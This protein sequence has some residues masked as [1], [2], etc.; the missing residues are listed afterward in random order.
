MD[1]GAGFHQLVFALLAVVAA[2]DGEAVVGADAFPVFA[3]G[4]VVAVAL[5]V[6]KA[7]VFHRQV[8]VVLD[9]FGAIV[10]RK[11][12]QVFL[13]VDIDLFFTSFV[14]K[15]QLVAALTLVG[16]GFQGGSCFVFWQRVRRCIG[17]VVGSSGN[18]RL[19]RVAVQEGNDHFVANSWQGHKAV[20]AT[21]PA[22]SHAQPGAGVF[23]ISGVTIPRKSY[24]HPTILIAVDFFPFRAGHDGHLGAVHHGFVV[25]HWPPRFV[26][27]DGG[28]VVVVA[29]GFAATFFFQGLEL[30]A[31]VGDGREQP[32]P[33]QGLA[34]VVL[35]FHFG[36]GGEIRAVAFAVGHGGVVPERIQSVLGERLAAGIGFV[37]AGVVVVLVVFPV[38]NTAS[39]MFMH[40]GVGGVLEGVVLHGHGGG[41]DPFFVGELEHAGL[42]CAATGFGVAGNR[43]QLRG[44]AVVVGKNQCRLFFAIHAAV[45]VAVVP[46]FFG[47]QAFQE[48]QVGFPV[49]D[50]VFPFFRGAFEVKDGVDDAPLFEQGAHDG[51]CGLGLE[52]AAVVHQA[53]S[54]QGWLDDHFVAGAA[55]AGVATDKLVHH[56][57]EAA[58]GLAVLPNH[59]VDRLFQNVGSGYIGV[60]T[61]QF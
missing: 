42:L 20:L 39:T 19:V 48:L 26:R 54:P 52:D 61:G 17:G 6:A 33:V 60:C 37:A 46:A 10:F 38:V 21:G 18:D 57:G 47:G 11:Q 32:F 43:L 40:K 8:A 12:V 51:V 49:L 24:F 29:G 31:G 15:P 4:G 13:G 50:A 34:V 28:E 53:Q 45:L 36:A 1:F 7:V 25:A 27:R 30:F 55:V 56:T 35:Q 44:V 2:I 23:V 3:F 14:F 41:F 22:L 16:F 59:Q 58:Q 9:D 5:G